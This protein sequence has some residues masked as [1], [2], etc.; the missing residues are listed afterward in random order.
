M[1]IGLMVVPAEVV[2]LGLVA[3]LHYLW[4]DLLL[5]CCHLFLLFSLP[6]SCIAKLFLNSPGGIR[7]LS[8]I[9]I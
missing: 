8:L 4:L 3:I 1:S 7:I 5:L 9:H 2:V 6:S